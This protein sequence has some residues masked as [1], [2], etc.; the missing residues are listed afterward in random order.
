[1]G[2][3]SFVSIVLS[4]YKSSNNITSSTYNSSSKTADALLKKKLVKSLDKLDYMN[5]QCQNYGLVALADRSEI[6]ME[7]INDWANDLSDL[8]FSI[9]LDGDATQ[10]A[11]ILLQEQGYRLY[12]DLILLGVTSILRT[13]F[14]GKSSSSSSSSVSDSHV[15]G[16]DSTASDAPVIMQSITAE[17]YYMDTDYNS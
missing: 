15:S 12:P 2:G 4:E 17:E 14:N 6:E 7:T 11:Q 1:M 3:E 5:K 10:G 13:E 9:S 8:Q 16:S